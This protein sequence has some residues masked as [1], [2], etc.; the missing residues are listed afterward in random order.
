MNCL[1]R[2][3][4]FAAARGDGLHPKLRDLLARSAAPLSECSVRSDGMLQAGP[5]PSSEIAASCGNVTASTEQTA[6]QASVVALG[7]DHG[8]DRLARLDRPRDS[9]AC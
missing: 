4:K 8:P 6:R 9:S 1:D 3:D 5:S 2:F 7:R